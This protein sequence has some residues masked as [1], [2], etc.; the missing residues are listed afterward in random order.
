MP[1]KFLDREEE[2]RILRDSWERKNFEFIIIYGRRRVGKTELI[3]KFLEN[4]RSLY[5]LCSERK[6]PY[7]LRRFS[8]KVSDFLGIPRVKFD[9]FQDAFDALLSSGEK[10]AVA[11]DEFGYLVRDDPGV[12]SDF[13]EIVDEKLRD[14]DIML[15]LCGSSISLMETRVLGPGSP[16]YGR[17]TRYLKI[18]P[19][20]L[21]QLLYWFPRTGHDDLVKIYGVTGGVAKYL[22]FFTGRDVEAEIERNFFDPSSFLYLDALKLLSDELRDYTTYIQVLEAISLGYNRVSE[23]ADYAFLEPKDTFFYLKVL[24]SLGIVRRVIPIFSPKR[25][26]RG[27]YE[28]RDNYFDFWFGFVSPFQAEIESR[29]EAVAVK[30]FRERFNS[31]LGRVFERLVPEMILPLLPFIPNRMGRWWKKDVEIDLVA[32]DGEG[33]L[34]FF[35]VK[36]SDINIKKARRLLGELEKKGEFL[37]YSK[38]RTKYYGLIGRKIEGKSDL[39]SE[40]YLIFDLGDLMAE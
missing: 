21:R 1:R 29:M 3:K 15:I 6:F 20:N 22:E 40:G 11:I 36:W 19:F 14:K 26:K 30:N 27:I 16:L 25:T 37:N 7:N 24:S 5:F 35:E 28:I 10:I 2:L 9:S 18:R 17:A 32:Y 33:K 23:I 38:V 34:A 12:L 31:Y 13:Q 8:E 4:K 39:R